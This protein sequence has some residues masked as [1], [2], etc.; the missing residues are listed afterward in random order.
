MRVSQ[1][2]ETV[3]LGQPSEIDFAKSVFENFL[4]YVWVDGVY[5]SR[6]RQEVYDLCET[7]KLEIESYASSVESV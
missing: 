5:G 4:E 2:N 1:V 6:D 3:D 7:L